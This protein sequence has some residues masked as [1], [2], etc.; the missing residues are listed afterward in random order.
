[1]VVTHKAVTVVVTVAIGG[2]IADAAVNAANV[3][4]VQ[5]PKQEALQKL[6]AKPS[7]VKK[8]GDGVAITAA[9]AQ[10]RLAVIQKRKIQRQLN[11]QAQRKPI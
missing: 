6:V 8:V 2:A 11:Y 1:M 4:L 3:Q 9:I 5:M 7:P 10:K